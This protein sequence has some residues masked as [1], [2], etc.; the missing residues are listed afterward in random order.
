MKQNRYRL[1]Q[2]LEEVLGRDQAATLMEHLPAQPW[3]ELA[4]RDEMNARF[5]AVDHR[6]EQLDQQLDQRFEQVGER[7]GAIDQRFGG[8][9]GHFA[10]LGERM[11]T[12]EYKLLAVIRSEMAGL[13]STQTKTIVVA[14]VAAI[15]ANSALMIGGLGWLTQQMS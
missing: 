4:Q 2:K 15:I 14:L 10:V 1:Q 6:F 9:D 13:I 8:V 7:L 12:M 5:D 3:H 11:Q